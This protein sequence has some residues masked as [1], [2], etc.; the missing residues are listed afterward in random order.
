MF[1]GLI[2]D[3]GTV[4]RISFGAMAD[5]WIRAFAGQ[6]LKLGESIAIDGTCLTVAEVKRGGF[7]P[8]VGRQ[9]PGDDHRRRE[10][11]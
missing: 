8:A 11:Q 2:Q 6:D 10:R 7:R 9:R 4:E 3:V 5:L 1:T